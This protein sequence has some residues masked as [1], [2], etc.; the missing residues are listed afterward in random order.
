M[1]LTTLVIPSYNEYDNLVKLIPSV[2]KLV[3]E[4]IIVE[5]GDKE[6]IEEF[7]NTF[8][9]VKLI[10][11]NHEGLTAA[12]L[13]GIKLASGTRVAVMDG[14]LSHAS[15]DLPKL[16]NGTHLKV[17]S[18]YVKGGKVINWPFR[19]HL[20]SK[21]L[22]MET[23]SLTGLKD[24]MSGFFA[25]NKLDVPKD[26]DKY[27]PKVLLEIATRSN[28]LIKEEIPITFFERCYGTTK[29]A[30]RKTMVNLLK[31]ILRL[32]VAKAKRFFK[33]GIFDG[34]G[35]ILVFVL[36]YLITENTNIHYLFAMLLACLPGVYIKFTLNKWFTFSN[37][38]PEDDNYEYNS[39]FLGNPIQK[40][41]KKSLAKKA[42]AMSPI[43]SAVILGCGSSPQVELWTNALAVD[44]NENKL[45][46]LHRNNGYCSILRSDIQSVPIQDKSKDFAVCLEVVEH[47]NN[48]NKALDEMVRISDNIII[49]TPET[50]GFRG[51]VWKLAEFCTPYKIEHINKLS[52][53][54]LVSDFKLRG[55]KE[56]DH[57]YVASCNYIGK[58]SK[59]K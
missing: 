15:A 17:G 42:K 23:Q 20:V 43:G 33:Y 6:K 38:S 1:T 35:A 7:C 36:T 25:I 59:V 58:F 44:I 2:K 9:N 5:D 24:S 22:C 32:H 52:R 13:R 19:R 45:N 14:D 29:F 26:V 48:H 55:Y 3:D 31:Q 18:R 50:K 27:A 39:W 8:R 53:D 34:F 57:S 56:T 37:G 21:L 46:Q 11:G 51:L 49:S 54:Q 10:E 12:I 4:V 41:W 16:L 30:N 40:W 28:N 47:L